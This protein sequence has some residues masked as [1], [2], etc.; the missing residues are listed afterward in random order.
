MVKISKEMGDLASEVKKDEETSWWGMSEQEAAQEGQVSSKVGTKGRYVD[1]TT[2][3]FADV[4]QDP[5]DPRIKAKMEKANEILEKLTSGGGV[6][7]P[8]FRVVKLEPI[9]W[10]SLQKIK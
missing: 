5:K 8:T 7:H 2:V 4:P 9:P 3:F 10:I 1:I 6:H